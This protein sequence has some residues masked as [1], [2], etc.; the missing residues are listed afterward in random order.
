MESNQ[1]VWRSGYS[2]LA[3]LGYNY[4]SWAGIYGALGI[5]AAGNNPGGRATASSLTD[6]H[7]NLWLFGGTGADSTGTESYLNDLWQFSPSTG[8]WTWMTGSSTVPGN[9]KPRP[10]VYGTLGVAA[11]GNTPGGRTGAIMWVDHNGNFWLFGGYGTD[12]VGGALNELNDFWEYSPTTNEWTWM[13]GLS[14]FETPSNLLGV[15]GTLGVPAAGN[16]PGARYLS[17]NWTDTNGNLWLFGGYGDSAYLSPGGELNDLWEFNPSTLQ[18]TWMAGSMGRNTLGV[19]GAKGVPSAANEPGGRHE[20]VQWI[21]SNGSFWLFGGVGFDSVTPSEDGALNDLWEFS[22]S[23]LEW[24]WVGGNSVDSS[25]GGYAGVYGSIGI[26]AATNMPGSRYSSVGWT[27]SSGNLWLFGGSGF[28]SVDFNGELNDLWEYSPVSNEWSWMSGSTVAHSGDYNCYDNGSI[29]GQ[30]GIF[31]T[32][33]FPAAAN[34]PGGNTGPSGWVDSTGNFWLFGGAAFDSAGHFGDQNVLWEYMM[35]QA[36]QAAT[37]AFSVAAGTYTAAQTVTISDTTAGAAIYF[38]TD[39]STPTKDS[40]LYTGPVSIASSETLQAIA[41]AAGYS[42]SPV[43]AVSYTIVQ[44][45]AITWPAPPPISYGTPLSATQLNAT[46]TVAGTFSYTP[47]AGTVLPAGQQTLTTT[48]TP[49]D[50]T[51]FTTATSTVTLTVNQAAPSITWTTPASITYGALLGPTQLNATSTTAGTFTYSPAT[52]TVLTAGPQTLTA[53]FTPTDATDYTTATSTVTLTVTQATPSVVWATPTPIT[54]GTPLSATQLNA[55]STVAGTFTYSPAIGTS[56]TAGTQT[57]TATFTPTD[58]TDYTTAS[59]SVTLTVNKTTPALTWS[60]P[61]PITYGTPLSATQLDATATVAGAFSY[62]PAA[63]TVLSA[64]QQTLTTVFT[65]T[66]ITDYTTATTSVTLTV[67]KVASSITWGPPVAITYGTPLSPTQLNASSTV[68]GS[69]TYSPAAG[70]VLTAGLQSLTATFTPTD[71]TDYTTSTASVTLTVNKVTPTIAWTAPAAITYGTPLTASQLNATSTVAG[72]FA[73]SP[74]AGTILNAGTQT[75]SVTFTPTDTTDYATASDSASLTVNKAALTVTWATPAAIPYGTALSATQLD[76][77]SNATG[78]YS[79]SP[80][81][82]TVLSVGNPTLSVTF[83]PSNAANY[84][85]TTAT[86]TVT[87]TVIKATPTITWATPAAISYGT[88]LSGI[89]LDASASIAGTFKYS[90]A[91]GTVL[92]AGTQTLVVTFTPHNTTDY[93]TATTSV[94]LIVNKSTPAITWATPNSIKYGTPLSGTQLDATSKVAGTFT[95]SPAAGTV[96]A[97]GNHTIT[98]TFTPTDTTDYT[99]TT[100]S[101][102]LN[103]NR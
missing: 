72:T 59:A 54:Y 13:G 52:G 75:L 65:P 48:F 47:A 46:S 25:T 32:L 41:T 1:W 23:T 15:Y 5:G 43:S 93:T 80:A 8:L 24:T 71:T 22:P 49:T 94:V 7:G 81:V 61:A 38:T 74:A 95:Y 69:F 50:T 14:T 58:T 91:S 88:K 36:Q 92:S 62:S 79:Y 100:A 37:P 10:G 35:P 82:G 60:T 76:A 12:S 56:L 44:S 103:V 33:D 85:T 51:D 40:T 21:D 57:L 84:T 11:P 28:D 96:L 6:Q 77:T 98:A 18:W 30:V 42:S 86:H 55:T 87:L 89:Q 31:G 3:P 16:Y 64:G 34:T 29:C 97:V 99:T 78:T 9:L 20:S 67:N 73:Y 2:T 101:V 26:P 68:A 83:T 53:T 45:P 17:A 66:D 19:Y 90:P 4:A 39:G 102:S 63:G 27:D 70:T